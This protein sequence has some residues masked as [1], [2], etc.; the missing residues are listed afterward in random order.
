V[1]L[2]WF[3][4]WFFFGRVVRAFWWVRGFAE[5]GWVSFGAGLGCLIEASTVFRVL[6]GLWVLWVF[7]V[8]FCGLAWMFL[9]ILHVYLGAPYGF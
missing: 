5:L 1:G 9:C 3:W 8:F 4:A 6:C 7:Q 2:Y